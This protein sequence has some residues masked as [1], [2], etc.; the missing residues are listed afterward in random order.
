[1]LL[2]LPWFNWG[3]PFM[4]WG[5]NYWFPNWWSL[6]VVNPVSIMFGNPIV[7]EF[8]IENDGKFV[9]FPGIFPIGNPPRESKGTRWKFCWGC[10]LS[11]S[12]IVVDVMMVVGRTTPNHLNYFVCLSDCKG[13]NQVGE[14]W[15]NSPRI[16]L[17]IP[18]CSISALETHSW[19]KKT[20]H[21]SRI[22]ACK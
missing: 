12:M 4:M 8:T 11:K 21:L 10:I 3:I 20:Y 7:I 16:V 5:T 13:L 2:G 1:M 19:I 22:H 14:L 9:H 15:H 18:L 6:S 17:R